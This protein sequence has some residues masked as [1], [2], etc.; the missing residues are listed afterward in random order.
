LPSD[1]VPAG[2][3]RA[4][5]CG[6]LAA[7]FE[8]SSGGSMSAGHQR[9]ADSH[10]PETRRQRRHVLQSSSHLASASIAPVERAV[11]GSLIARWP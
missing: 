10:Y 9:E 11:K 4:A 8:V 5:A 6:W 3:T 7:G 2:V 1:D